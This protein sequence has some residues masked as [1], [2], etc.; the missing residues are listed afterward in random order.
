M[1]IFQ[2]IYIFSYVWKL[3]NYKHFNDSLLGKK[4]GFNLS[5]WTS[6]DE[7][8]SILQ[9]FLKYHQPLRFQHHVPNQHIFILI[10]RWTHTYMYIYS[11][12]NKFVLNN[13]ISQFSKFIYNLDV[14]II[15]TNK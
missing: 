11:M 10:N 13:I 5:V 1:Y 8:S 4:D 9:T 14:R 2:H 6:F 15:I 3:S 7:N 12:Q